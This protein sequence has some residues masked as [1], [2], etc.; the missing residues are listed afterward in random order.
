MMRRKD[1]KDHLEA[2]KQ[3][4]LASEKVKEMDSGIRRLKTENSAKFKTQ[5]SESL[6]PLMIMKNI[7]L[8]KGRLLWISV[9]S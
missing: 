2:A 3:E 5:E 6:Q 8:L 7:R 1:M 4:H 9:F